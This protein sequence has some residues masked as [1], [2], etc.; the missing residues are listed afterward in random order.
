MI[1]NTAPPP[2]DIVDHHVIGV[3]VRSVYYIIIHA[4]DM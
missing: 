3:L 4:N 2:D 1:D